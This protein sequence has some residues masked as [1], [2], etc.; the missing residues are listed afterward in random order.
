MF[1]IWLKLKAGFDLFINHPRQFSFDWNGDWFLLF[2]ISMNIFVTLTKLLEAWCARLHWYWCVC[3]RTNVVCTWNCMFMSN[4][5]NASEK[6]NKHNAILL[7]YNVANV[8]CMFQ[9]YLFACNL[10]IHVLEIEIE[11]HKSRNLITSL[12]WLFSASKHYY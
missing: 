2:F 6:S 4:V 10:K 7:V 3:F 12:A 11:R 5:N 1:S 8:F 9:N